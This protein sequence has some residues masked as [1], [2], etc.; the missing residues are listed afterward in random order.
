MK[1]VNLFLCAMFVFAGLSCQQEE[2]LYSCNEKI[3]SW[4]KSNLSYVKSMD[5]AEWE[6]VDESLK[7]GCYAAFSPQQKQ[8]LWLGKFGEALSLDWSMEEKEHIKVLIDFVQT[9]L[10]YF[11]SAKE[12]TDKEIETIEV[13]AYEWIKKAESQL[14]W[15]RKLI[16]GLVASPNSI[17]DKEGTLKL[18]H[19]NSDKRV[20]TRTETE[21]E[22][23]CS[24]SSNW[25]SI[26]IMV[27]CLDVPCDVVPNDCGFLWLYDCDG[28]C[29]GI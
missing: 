28:R 24:T 10:S 14:R 23:N 26:D 3:D 7:R 16:G 18:T 22:C 21:V 9:H 4:V 6:G 12:E 1:T 13:F 17:I 5:R 29:N 8:H 19:S 11:D 25:C 2:L 15:N 27:E 20:K